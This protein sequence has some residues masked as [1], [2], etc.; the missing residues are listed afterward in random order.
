ML[1]FYGFCL[2]HFGKFFLSN[3]SFTIIQETAAA[4]KLQSVFR[5]RM[6]E[7]DLVARGIKPPSY[8]RRERLEKEL[9]D[10]VP[11]FLQMCGLHLLFGGLSKEEKREERRERDKEER[12]IRIDKERKQEEKKREYRK[13][14][15]KKPILLE[16]V[17]VVEE[18]NVNAKKDQTSPPS[19]VYTFD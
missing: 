17:E 3:L 16:E 18:I 15:S 6:V 4:I 11:E 10:D 12:Q 9:Y 7:K 13:L 2:K 5:R 8:I 14:K 1:H 19:S